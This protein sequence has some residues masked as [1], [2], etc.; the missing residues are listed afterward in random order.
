M[1]A[2]I[3]AGE[4]AKYTIFF[5]LLHNILY[6]KSFGGHYCHS[7]T[8]LLFHIYIYIIKYI[9]F[10]RILP[11]IYYINADEREHKNNDNNNKLKRGKNETY[12][13]KTCQRKLIIFIYII[14]IYT[15]ISYTHM[16]MKKCVYKSKYK[17]L[18]F[19][20]VT[21]IYLCCAGNF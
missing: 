17:I 8:P 4:T 15:Y 7:N 12:A 11:S 21:F 6:H 20:V 5:L 18:V 16:D 13:L 14:Y 2:L 19:E 3:R 9:F 10:T 1:I